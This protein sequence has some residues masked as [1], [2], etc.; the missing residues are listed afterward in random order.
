VITGFG[1]K[2]LM[3]L[4]NLP[5]RKTR[6]SLRWATEAY[7]ARWKIEETIRFIKQSYQLEGIRL[8]THIR[9]Q[10][11]M[12][13]VMAVAY[14]TIAYLGVRTKLRVLAGH[15]LKAAR[16]IFGIPEFRFYALADGIKEYLFGQKRGLYGCF[17]S[18]S[19]ETGQRWL[20]FPSNFGGTP[21]PMYY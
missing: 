2:P 21:Q 17:L 12:A 15:V 13:L 18:P 16:R 14:F 8:L 7:T 9:L 20:L 5:I 4:T 11:M 3:L 1:E 19:S 6:K 10:N